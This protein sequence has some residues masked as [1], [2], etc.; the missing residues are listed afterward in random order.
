M[1]AHCQVILSAALLSVAFAPS[2]TL[3]QTRGAR[4]P[5]FLAGTFKGPQGEPQLGVEVAE[6]IRVRMLRTFPFPPRPG[7]LRV[8]RKSEVDDQ[9]LSGSEPDFWRG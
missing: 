5:V 4:N 9:R 8:V 2:D 7:A 1:R 6:A 3:A